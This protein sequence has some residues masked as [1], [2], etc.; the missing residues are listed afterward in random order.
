MKTLKS[1]LT[2]WST[3]RG[4]ALIGA[5]MAGIHP[6][7]ANALVNVGDVVVSGQSAAVAAV[8]MVGAWEAFRNEA[9]ADKTKR[10]G[11]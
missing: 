8:S 7:A 4:L 6:D 11:W 10:N 5:A 2:Q 3:W 1:Y 9:K